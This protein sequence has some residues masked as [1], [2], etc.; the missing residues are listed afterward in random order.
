VR[1]YEKEIC[2]VLLRFGAA[3]HGSICHP[4]PCYNMTHI[5]LFS[6]AENISVDAGCEGYISGCVSV[7]EEQKHAQTAVHKLAAHVQWEE[8]L[9]FAL[10][11]EGTEDT[12]ALDGEV[13]LSL[14]CC[15]R[16]SHNSTLGTMRFKLAD[17]SMM[18]DADCWV[19]LQPPKQVRNIAY[20]CPQVKYL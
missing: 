17:V 9:V 5:P 3:S 4:V 15:D 7:S 18:L 16:F 12:D 6:A 19:D 10:P 14:H 11:V 13:A 20:K 2:L 1:R 8:E